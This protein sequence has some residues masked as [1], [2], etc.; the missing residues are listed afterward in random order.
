MNLLHCQFAQC[1]SI[2]AT[3]ACVV[4]LADMQDLASGSK[5]VKNDA[6]KIEPTSMVTCQVSYTQPELIT[7]LPN[8]NPT[9][10][11]LSQHT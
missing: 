3:L 10:F 8:N 4:I 5:N 9:T 11:I 2:E 1:N 6:Q 7:Q